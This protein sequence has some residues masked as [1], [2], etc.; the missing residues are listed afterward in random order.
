LTRTALWRK[1]LAPFFSTFAGSQDSGLASDEESRAGRQR[2][3][4]FPLSRRRKRLNGKSL[5][6]HTIEIQPVLRLNQAQNQ[7]GVARNSIH[8]EG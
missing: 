7:L 1:I 8:K 4:P 5:G 3:V 2:L 6:P